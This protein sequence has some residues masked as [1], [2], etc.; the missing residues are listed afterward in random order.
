MEEEKKI[1]IPVKDYIQLLVREAEL[2]NLEAMGVDNWCGYGDTDSDCIDIEQ[3]E[4]ELN[5][6]F[7]IK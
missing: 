4:E 3:Y 5:K 6:R 2:D 7:G 1:T